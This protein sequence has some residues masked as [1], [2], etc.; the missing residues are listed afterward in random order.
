VTGE[1]W[2]ALRDAGRSAGRRRRRL[3]TYHMTMT[4]L[5][6]LGR[7]RWGRRGHAGRAA[8]AEPGAGSAGRGAAQ[9][10]RLDYNF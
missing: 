9:R 2:N 8:K 7:M 4:E 5:D 3:R 6:Q 10:H 1:A